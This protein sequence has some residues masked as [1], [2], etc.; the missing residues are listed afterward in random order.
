KRYISE[1]PYNI[2]GAKSGNIPIVLKKSL[3]FMFVLVIA[4]EYI[5][6]KHSDIK[7]ETVDTKLNFNDAIRL[8]FSTYL[9]KFEIP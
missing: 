1:I 5:N 8:G 2:V 6:A 3:N 4:Y 7:D 9:L